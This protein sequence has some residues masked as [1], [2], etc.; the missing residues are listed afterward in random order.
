MRQLLVDDDAAAL[1]DLEAGVAGEL[2]ARPDAGGEDD[3]VDV[4]RARAS[5]ERQPGDRRPSPSDRLGHRAG[6]DGE[7]ELLDVPAQR[8]AAGVVDLHRHQPR[9]DLDDV[10]LEAE[11]AQGVGRLE[12]EQPAADDG[13]DASRVSAASRIASRS[14]MVR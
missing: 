14:S 7:A 13:A 11:L 1:A 4:E 5:G 9:R 3:D 2:V 6:V 10:G 8:R 12:A